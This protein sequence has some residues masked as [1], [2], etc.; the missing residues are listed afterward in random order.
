MN[1]VDGELVWG[2][3]S[4]ALALAL[5]QRHAR[6]LIAANNLIAERRAD[7]AVGVRLA[8]LQALGRGGA[9]Q[10]GPATVQPPESDDTIPAAQA[11][12]GPDNV[13]AAI[14]EAATPD[15]TTRPANEPDETD[16]ESR[17]ADLESEIRVTAFRVEN[18]NELANENADVFATA[19]ESDEKR[20]DAIEKAY[21]SD[22]ARV[23]A[24]E[25]RAGVAERRAAESEQ[26]L[27]AIEAIVRSLPTAPMATAHACP[28]CRR[29]KLVSAV[30]CPVCGLGVG[31]TGA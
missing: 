23:E 19:L 3:R 4:I 10:T 29:S 31:P 22:H 7:G 14:A 9:A 17:V 21:R 2:W 24:L 13:T 1:S 18:A 11:A 16:L 20:L 5:S 26:R 28:R 12:P 6:D 27:A 8:D 30:G 25:R 15:P